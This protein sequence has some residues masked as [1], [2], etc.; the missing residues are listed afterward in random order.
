MVQAEQ[1]YLTIA[2]GKRWQPVRAEVQGFR[3]DPL[4]RTILHG[5]TLR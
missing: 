3:V 2:Y 4:T 5:V 1:P